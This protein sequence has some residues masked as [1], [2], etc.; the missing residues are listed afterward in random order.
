[1]FKKI[2]P[3]TEK[4]GG[5]TNY[6]CGKC[7]RILAVTTDYYHGKIQKKCQWCNFRIDWRTKADIHG[8]P[9]QSTI[10]KIPIKVER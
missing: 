9:E 10:P 6:R 4:I 3:I 5:L 7:K 8:I 2:R 1:M